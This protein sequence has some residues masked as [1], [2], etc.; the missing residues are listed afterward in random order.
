MSPANRSSWSD[1][2]IESVGWAAA[3]VA[4]L[5]QNPYGE[6][7]PEADRFL[8]LQALALVAVILAVVGAARQPAHPA[9]E[10]LRGLSTS[11]IA[12]WA[13]ALGGAGALAAVVS[14]DPLRSL[15]G[16]PP[17]LFG[18][19]SE[20]AL[21]LLFFL[22]APRLATVD[23]RERWET[24]L[25]AATGAL[26]AYALLQWAGL[27][28]L[29]WQ[30]D[31]QGRPTAAQGNPLFLA[32]ALAWLVPIAI[33]RA[34]CR[35]RAGE[36][37][38]AMSAALLAIL[39]GAVLVRTGA[40]GPLLGLAV[41]ALVFAAVAGLGSPFDRPRR[42]GVALAG[43]LGFA[44][45]AGAWVALQ[46]TD[47]L[48]GTASQRL[49]LWSSVVRLFEASPP[50]RLGI[51]FGAESLP[52]VLPPHLPP[53]LP[54]RIWRPDLYHDRAH[55]AVLDA[56]AAG[57]LLRLLAGL[58]LA[59]AAGGAALRLAGA[60][61]PK[62]DAAS[63]PVSPA[64]AGERWRFV[65]LTAALAGHAVAAQFG[66]AT[67]ATATLFW[68]TLALLAGAGMRPAGVRGAGMRSAGM[69]SAGVVLPPVGGG[70][71]AAEALRRHARS[72]TRTRWLAVGGLLAVVAFGAWV[73]PQRDGDAMGG[74]V[75]LLLLLAAGGIGL[76]FVSTL[77]SSPGTPGRDRASAAPTPLAHVP[78]MRKMAAA[79]V[80]SAALAGLFLVLLP[81]FASGIALKAGRTALEAGRAD[82]AV[83]LLSRAH[84]LFP[85]FE[86]PAVA[87]AR[88]EQR[89]A[90]RAADGAS[91]DAA[92]DRAAA[93]LAEARRRHRGL[94]QLALE[95]AHLAARRADGAAEPQLRGL[96]FEK[97]VTSYREVLVRDPQSSTVHR[98]LGAALLALGRLA[99]AGEELEASVRLA[100]RSLES[101]L[102]LGRLRLTAGDEAG[103]RAAFEAARDIDAMRARRLLE[104]LVRARPGDPEAL[105]DLALYEI[106]EGRRKEA[107][108]ALERAMALTPPQNLPPL[109]RLTGLAAKVP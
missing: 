4:L 62:A 70:K 59:V 67:A 64:A 25:L 81:Q 65:A 41:A 103:A 55:N 15:F 29:R 26:V 79:A 49:L 47:R 63:D 11:P 45:I 35:W 80:V 14:V 40:R 21:L 48:S 13:L 52:I 94:A 18:F 102:L 78:A 108:A 24:A 31:W 5:F 34:V 60:L 22:L 72:A 71:R 58:G 86:D 1:R 54:E 6:L 92:F 76:A 10:A 50:L 57:G 88:A 38:A 44:L 56:V 61:R 9:M 77:P 73:P 7:G 85:G 39:A 43:V 23:S 87:L 89:L 20:L 16:A 105:R 51:G 12:R 19:A 107:I 27:D 36:H 91:R 3:A 28:P 83:P 98:G 74:R 95:E 100:P 30:V 32:Q 42:A 104:G 97:A 109:V 75:A 46:R 66:V 17:R 82:L 53:E 84:R 69:R 96:L 2:A 90:E 101:R 106:V 37:R 33:G 93:V 99:E 8:V 68:L